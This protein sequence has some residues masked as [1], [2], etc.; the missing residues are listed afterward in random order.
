MMG[1]NFHHNENRNAYTT[2]E[3]DIS[4]RQTMRDLVQFENISNAL[5][6]GCGGGIYSK[7]LADMGVASVTGVDFSEAILEGA[8]ENCKEYKNITFKYGNAL[9]TGLDS[10]SF[11]LL[12]ER[13]LIHH[14]EDLHSCFKEAYRI[15]ETNG[16]YIVQDRTPE[17]CLFEGNNGHI[18]GYFFELFPRLIEKETNRR[19]DSSLVIEKLKEV[20]FKEVEEVK[21]WETRKVYKN[22]GHLL[23]DISN[24]TG[25]SILHELDDKELKLLI[26][27]IDN[28]ISIDTD[29]VEKDRWTIWKAIKY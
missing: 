19:H 23:K 4:W 24:R 26:N 9:D 20:G 28:L 1:I 17:D 18:R 10:N 3:A 8:R 14:I 7:A 11:N 25:R 21:L 6:V 2:R 16:I 15:L 5:D 27:Y 29:I 12:L 13:A 22:K